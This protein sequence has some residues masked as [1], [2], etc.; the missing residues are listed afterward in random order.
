MDTSILS[1]LQIIR[2]QVTDTLDFR[3]IASPRDALA[4]GRWAASTA[5]V[6]STTE[7]EFSLEAL[8]EHLSLCPT[9]RSQDVHLLERVNPDE[10]TARSLLAH[11]QAALFGVSECEPLGQPRIIDADRL[12]LV[13]RRVA[14]SGGV[15][16]RSFRRSAYG[17]RAIDSAATLGAFNP[18]DAPALVSTVDGEVERP[19]RGYARL[20]AV[21]AV[22]IALDVLRARGAMPYSPTAAIRGSGELAGAIALELATVGVRVVAISAM[23]SATEEISSVDS[24]AGPRRRPPKVPVSRNAALSL[25]IDEIH[26]LP[27]DV[28]I[29]CSGDGPLN[30]AH[31]AEVRAQV[32]VEATPQSLTQ[33]ADRALRTRDVAVVP[34]IL[35]TAAPM[36]A[37]CH[38]DRQALRR[39]LLDVARSVH[40]EATVRGRSVRQTAMDLA[41][42]R[43][44]QRPEWPFA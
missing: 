43:L 17:E 4:G 33:G 10:V 31:A 13:E 34:D 38:A 19:Y 12:A 32:V 40:H 14:Q 7:S 6:Q 16:G 42:Q 41:I 20:T 26:P 36:I 1:P 5:E 27:V 23:Q 3:R 37:S 44:Q 11:A 21:G 39:S 18:G 28:L 29:L 24:G 15:A 35:A 8:L 30:E 9:T 2:A 25:P 22:A